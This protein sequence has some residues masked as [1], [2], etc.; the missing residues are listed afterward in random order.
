MSRASDLSLRYATELKGYG[1]SLPDDFLTAATALESQLSSEELDA[2]AQSG[3]DLAASSLRAWEAA[4]E[5]FRASPSVAERLG[6]EG[7]KTWSIIAG[8]LSQRSSLMAAA[9]LKSTPAVLESI[10]VHDL[11]HARRL[12]RL[13]VLLGEHLEQHLVAGAARRIF[14]D[15]KPVAQTADAGTIWPE[16]AK[17]GF[18]G[19]IGFGSEKFVGTIESMRVSTSARY[20]K[21]FAPPATFAKDRDTLAL[22][23]F[24][25]GQGDTLKD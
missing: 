3:I 11:L 16:G 18:L 13:D 25:E 14:V 4:A 1:A 7:L 23:L 20:D 19:T 21:E 12:Q 17:D 2:W 22:Y 8:A 15:G 10:G 5:Y 9:F 24:D 6:P